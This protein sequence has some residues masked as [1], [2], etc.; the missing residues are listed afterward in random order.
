MTAAATVNSGI[1]RAGR[2]TRESLRAHRRHQYLRRQKLQALGLPTS[3][4]VDAQPARDHV[5]HLRAQ[6]MG[7][8]RIAARAGVHRTTVEALLYGHDGGPP[9]RRLHRD[10]AAKLLATEADAARAVPAGQTPGLGV[11]RRFQSLVALGWTARFLAGEIGMHERNIY[12]FLNGDGHVLDVTAEKILA[13]YGRL[14]DKRPPDTVGARR[15]RL[16]AARLGWAV[17]AAWDDFDDP[18][19]KPAGVGATVRHRRGTDVDVTAVARLVAGDIAASDVSPRER[20]AAVAE[21]TGRGLSTAA[22]AA[23]I[24]MAERSVV[25]YRGRAS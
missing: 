17:P 9:S 15:A 19:A 8:E 6:G 16:R 20:M 23:R 3:E 1:L 22:I 4:F 14:W 7:W 24:R 10:N 2:P 21:L 11:R 18:Q 5:N 12:S 13:V 25:R